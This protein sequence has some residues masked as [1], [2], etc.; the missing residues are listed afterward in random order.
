MAARK[1]LDLDMTTAGRT[2]AQR[3]LLTKMQAGAGSFQ[4]QDRRIGT[5]ITRRRL[6][7]M[8]AGPADGRADEVVLCMD[9]WM[10]AEENPLARPIVSARLT[11]GQIVLRLV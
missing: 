2:V 4:S 8:R 6:V 7:R 5:E 11:G 1:D 3:D 9:V 10:G